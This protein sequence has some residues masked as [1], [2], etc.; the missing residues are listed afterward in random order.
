MIL[1]RKQMADGTWTFWT[2]HGVSRRFRTHLD[3]E[4]CQENGCVLHNPSD[5]IQNRE[6]W[7]YSW[8]TD[9][10][11]M[12]R[13]CEHGI[14]HPDTDSARFLRR[15]GKGYENIHGCDGCEWCEWCEFEDE[16][17]DDE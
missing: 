7:P 4:D 17:T 13:I 9:R 11:I 5:T 8:R 1:Q 2:M 15:N 14:G 10:G 6:N 12:E 3:S 16:E